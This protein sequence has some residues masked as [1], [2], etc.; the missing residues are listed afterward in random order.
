MPGGRRE[1]L[2]LLLDREVK[3]M[4]VRMP[5]AGECYRHFKGNKY[6]VLAVARHTET[7][8]EL[9]IYQGLYGNHPVYARPL[10]MFAGKVER[11]KF[12]EVTQEY[13]FEL[14]EDTAVTDAGEHEM[15][16]AFLELASNQERL[17][18]LLRR[19]EEMTDAFLS[20]AAQSLD[21]AERQE[22]TEAQRFRDLTDYLRTLLRYEKRI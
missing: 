19:E 9:V 2:S 15:L 4:E 10:E 3:K 20:A 1:G 12:P 17:D 14:L 8:E 18:F 11:E 21:F 6:Q 16:L 7:D 22:K 5:K 13:R